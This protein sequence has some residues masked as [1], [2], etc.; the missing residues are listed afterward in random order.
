MDWLIL[1]TTFKA[2]PV[3]G[4]A[5]TPI[6]ASLKLHG[7]FDPAEIEAI[8]VRAHPVSL[9]VASQRFPGDEA[10]AKFSIPYCVAVALLKGRVRQEEFSA[11]HIGS[12]QIESILS[13]IRLIPDDTLSTIPG[14][15]PARVTVS[16]PG[17]RTL[18]ATAEVRKGDPEQPMTPDEKRSKVI[19]LIGQPWRIK[20]EAGLNARLSGLAETSNV[21]AWAEGLREVIEP[22]R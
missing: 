3:C 8:E 15:R 19:T 4:H 9:Q 21:L 17:E 5:M 7:Q 13:K 22:N 14:R 18:T 1:D 16:L 6:E 20:D 10:Q 2:Y 11:E 12:K